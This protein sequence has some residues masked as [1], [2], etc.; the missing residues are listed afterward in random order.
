MATESSKA[1]YIL[2]K[3]D[4]GSTSSWYLQETGGNENPSGNGR[5]IFQF[6]NSSDTSLSIW[7][8]LDWTKPSRA[9]WNHSVSVWDGSAGVRNSFLNGSQLSS[10]SANDAYKGQMRST[11]TSGA[12]LCLGNWWDGGAAQFP[13]KLDE[14]RISKVARSAE[15][16]KATYDTIKDN[17]NFTA[18]GAAREN[19]KLG[20]QIIVR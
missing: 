5:Y 14:V 6:Y 11:T 7:I 12:K 18:Y 2:R 16:I 15:W 4:G 10:Y 1:R 20:L 8:N 13:G 19:G 17:A 3:Y 9:D